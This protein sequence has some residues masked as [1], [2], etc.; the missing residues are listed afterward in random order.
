VRL[1]FYAGLTIDE[2]AKA[3]D[4]SASTIKREWSFARAFLFRV[5]K[6]R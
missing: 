2:T 5:L 4:T 3:L 6:D 1:R